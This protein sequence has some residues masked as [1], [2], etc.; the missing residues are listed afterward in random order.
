MRKLWKPDLDFCE[1]CV[2]LCPVFEIQV[3]G[4]NVHIA[5]DALRQLRFQCLY[6]DPR[7][8]VKSKWPQ[9]IIPVERTDDMPD[10]L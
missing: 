8:V 7:E 10:G 1:S 3:S 9:K 2:I 4:Q 5:D 6:D